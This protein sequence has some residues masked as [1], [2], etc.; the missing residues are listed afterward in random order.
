MC[1]IS[2]CTRGALD[3]WSRGRSTAV[4]GV[5]VNLIARTLAFIVLV[6]GVFCANDARTQSSEE[7]V[8]ADELR[9]AFYEHAPRS[10]AAAMSKAVVAWC[11]SERSA[12]GSDAV[13]WLLRWTL[14]RAAAQ[15]R[16]WA[17]RKTRK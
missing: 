12:P 11:S 13:S 5:H 6:A 3:A 15:P 4:F 14:G 2:L 17:C 8:I 7:I 10:L 9:T 1:V 16:R